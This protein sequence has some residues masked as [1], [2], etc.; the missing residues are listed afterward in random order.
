MISISNDP[1]LGAEVATAALKEGEMRR[2][3]REFALEQARSEELVKTLGQSMKQLEAFKS[4]RANRKECVDNLKVATERV[5]LGEMQVLEE[6]AEAE[7][8]PL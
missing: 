2:L 4:A 3:E 6:E 8:M 1:L 7:R 5:P